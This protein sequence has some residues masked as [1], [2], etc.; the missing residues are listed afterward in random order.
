MEAGKNSSPN[1]RSWTVFFILLLCNVL[2]FAV[3]VL[4]LRYIWVDINDF[5][6]AATGIVANW[7]LGILIITLLIF[8]YLLCKGII[9]MRNWMRGLPINIGL[10]AKTFSVIIFIVWN[11]MFGL[12]ISE[13]GEFIFLSAEENYS[14]PDPLICSEGQKVRTVYDWE[15]K[16]RPELLRLFSEQ[17]Y[18]KVPGKPKGMSFTLE[19]ID[20]NALHGTAI[21]KEVSVYFAGPDGPKMNILIYLPKKR[22]GAVPAFLGLNFY[23]NHVIHPDPGISIPKGWVANRRRYGIVNHRATEA[24]R[25]ARASYWQ[26]ER[27]L[28]RGYALATVYY[29]DIDPDFND[30][31]Q[32][33]VHPLFYRAGRTVPAPDEWGSISAWAWGLSRVMD[34]LERDDDID[35]RKVAVMG[36]SRLGKT[37]LWAGALDR[38]FAM[39]ISNNSGCMG[40]ALSRRRYGETIEYITRTFP[41]WFCKNFEKYRE[42]EG[43]LPVDQH[44]L[45]ALIAPRPV[46]VASAEMDRWA[47]PAG[48]FL[49]AKHASPVYRLFDR[50]GLAADKMPAVN[51]P[52]MSIIG[53]HI[54]SGGHQV[55]A[56]DWDRFLDFADR[57][58]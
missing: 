10:F 11:A 2:V 49:S 57:Y 20:E 28:G 29:G 58:L 8:S 51:Q 15:N 9:S 16:R 18:G 32:N 36:H 5:L 6:I 30:G 53:Y 17:V 22:K 52:I 50:E 7:I 47:D 27:I 40:A 1:N 12:L 19:S 44:M 43:E 31:F 41:H 39:V 38:R 55:T 45:I 35:H 26:V 37:A 13:A 34:Y 21:R 48:E 24:S 25:G 14:L 54:R 3:T 42:R 46:Y 4:L 33:G 56:Y 23:G